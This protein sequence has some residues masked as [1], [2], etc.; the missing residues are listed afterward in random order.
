MP[1]TDRLAE[2]VAQLTERD[3]EFRAFEAIASNRG[4][5][6]EPLWAL[7]KLKQVIGYAAGESIEKAVNK[8]KI[9]ADG[10][11]FLIKEHFI[12]GSLFDEPNE[13][14]LTK[15]SAA[16]VVLNA[17]VKKKE[18]A[19]AQAYFVL[20]C[21]RQRLEDEKR[22]RT[23]LDVVTENG[24]LSRVASGAG[25]TN[26]A[27]FNGMGISALYGGISVDEIKRKKGISGGDW[28]DQ[29]TSEELAANLF[30]ITQTAAALKRQGI[31]NENLACQTHKRVA[32]GV[33]QA[34][35]SAGNTLP[36]NLPK[37]AVKIDQVA[38][39]VKN[40]ILPASPPASE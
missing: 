37:A 31:K 18:V 21:D 6:E 2:V 22:L 30:R 32:S 8:A 40:Q 10:A 14:F 36:E 39:S 19:L 5:D 25:V 1:N 33:R 16:L 34:I 11:G 20:K 12:D 23:R 7:S 29:I 15:Y 26:F 27:K 28:L 13:M 9:A 35:R 38:T 3:Q 24:N 4:S 17:D